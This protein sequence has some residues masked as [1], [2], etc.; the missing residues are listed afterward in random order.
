VVMRSGVRIVASRT[1]SKRLRD[2]ALWSYRR[3]CIVSSGE[4]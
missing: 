1:G 4:L 3:S 2:L